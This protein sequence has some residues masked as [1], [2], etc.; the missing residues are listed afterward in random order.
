[1][2]CDFTETV[3][4]QGIDGQSE[5]DVL[6]LICTCLCRVARSPGPRTVLR[7]PSGSSVTPVSGG[8]SDD[9]D[10]NICACALSALRILTRHTVAFSVQ[11]KLANGTSEE[12]ASKETTALIEGDDGVLAVLHERTSGP[13]AVAAESG[14]DDDDDEGVDPI[15]I[16]VICMV[17]LAVVGAVVALVIAKRRRDAAITSVK[18]ERQMN[19][20]VQSQRD[21][22]FQ[23]LCVAV[24]FD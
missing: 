13:A 19:Q 12:D 17:A 21:T 24:R 10:D 8:A 20:A 3:R 6:Q 18:S 1:M 16:A 23:S 9:D 14:G 7:L 11:R 22:E 5:S 15:T 2:L 4:V